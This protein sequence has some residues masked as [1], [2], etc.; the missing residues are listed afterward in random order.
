[1][2]F[3]QNYASND[4]TDERKRSLYQ[5]FTIRDAFLVIQRIRVLLTR[6]FP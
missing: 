3:N 6:G 1:M 2:L 5:R 4:L